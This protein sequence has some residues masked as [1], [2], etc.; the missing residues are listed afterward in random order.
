MI[1]SKN[2]ISSSMQPSLLSEETLAT[3]SLTLYET[4]LSQSADSE[5]LLFSPTQSLFD[6]DDAVI[7]ESLEKTETIPL[8]QLQEK[9]EQH[10]L[11]LKQ[12]LQQ[13]KQYQLQYQQQ[14]QQLLQQPQQQNITHT[15]LQNQY[16][17]KQEQIMQRQMVQ[18]Q[19]IQ[20]LEKKIHE[21]QQDIFEH[22]NNQQQN[23][24]NYQCQKKQQNL[25][26]TTQP[27][28]NQLQQVEENDMTCYCCRLKITPNSALESPDKMKVLLCSE[29]YSQKENQN[30]N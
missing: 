16:H 28:Q 17:Q 1:S 8:Q 15:D 13:Q 9:H 5:S 24:I 27:S 11:I 2:Q 20:K 10:Q 12:L 30:P 4:S 26:K 22:I 3:S 25:Q 14:Y 21:S 7:V 23:Q 6:I 29:C 18:Q 19:I